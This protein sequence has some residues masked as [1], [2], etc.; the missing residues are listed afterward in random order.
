MADLTGFATKDKADEGV[1]LPVKIDG[2]KLPLAIKV[3]GSDSDVVREYERKRIRNMHLGK[4]GKNAPDEE[5]MENLLD[6]IDEAVLI[7]M[8]GIYAYDWKKEKVIEGEETKLDGKVLKNDRESYKYLIEKM[9][10]IKDWVTTNSN[11]RGNFLS[12]GKK[13]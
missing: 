7:R 6:T 4:N 5:D 2:V 9:P 11:N 3:Y 8:G 10:A 1:I 13:N 12:E